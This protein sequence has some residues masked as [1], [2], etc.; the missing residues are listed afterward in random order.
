MKLSRDVLGHG[1]SPTLG[2]MVSDDGAF[3][4]VTCERSADH[5]DHPCIPA[6]TY[7]MGYAIHHPNGPH[8]Y[9]CPEVLDVPGRT[10][11]HIHVANNQGELLG[12]IAVGDIVSADGESIER[13]QD[14]F[15]RLM[16]YL[17]G[18]TSW[19]LEIIDPAA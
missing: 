3:S 12:C 18:V 2:R 5:E 7:T 19:T 4:C 10:C 6:G 1:G 13:S 15:D 16:R 9:R 14:A 11:I 17:E 8:P